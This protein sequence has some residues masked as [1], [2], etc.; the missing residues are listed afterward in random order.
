MQHLLIS[1]AVRPLLPSDYPSQIES[2]YFYLDLEV[3]STGHIIE[4]GLVSPYFQQRYS[5]EDLESLKAILL[6][7]QRQGLTVIGH[8]FRRFDFPY[9]IEWLPELSSLTV[10]DTLE[11]SVILYPLAESHRLQK[12]YKPSQYTGNNPLEDALA[13]RLLLYQ[14]LEKLS[15]IEPTLA[16]SY[17]WLLSCGQDT[18]D[19]AYQEL[20]HRLGYDLTEVPGPNQLAKEI[21]QSFNWQYLDWFWQNAPHFN[22]NLRLSMAAL[23]AWYKEQDKVKTGFPKW[24]THLLEFQSVLDGLSP[25][26][27][28]GF[29]YHFYLE[30]FGLTQFRPPQEEAIQTII[31]G[32]RPLIIMATG[33]GKSL[34]YQLPALMIYQK[35]RRLTVVVS[36]LQALMADQVQDLQ[37]QG[38]NFATYINSSL[39]SPE[40]RQRLEEISQGKKGLLYISPEQLR[41]ISIRSLLEELLPAFWV[42]DE[43]HSI[44]QWGHN[45]RPDYCYVP[46]YI[47]SLYQQKNLPLPR[48]ALLTATATPQV[49]EDLLKL[50]KTYQL[51]IDTEIIGHS[52]RDNLN[53]QVIPSN[54]NRDFILLEQVKASLKQA[55]CIIVYTNTR[56]ETEIIAQQLQKNNLTAAYYHSGL[57]SQDKQDILEDFKKG[58][59][60]IVVATSAFGMGINRADVRSVIHYKMSFSLENYIQESGRAGRDNQSA[61]CVLLFDIKDAETIFFLQS[62]HHLSQRDLENIFVMIRSLRD[63]LYETVKEADFFWVTSRELLQGSKIEESLDAEQIDTKIKVALHH[64][65]EFGLVQREENQSSFIEFHLLHNTPQDSL[66]KF[67]QY[68][69]V[70]QFS[71]SQNVLFEKL[72]YALHSL[73][74]YYKQDKISLEVLSDEAGLNITELKERIEELKMS[75]VCAYQIPLIIQIRKGVKKDAAIERLTYISQLENRLLKILLEID[76]DRLQIN[77]RSLTTILDPD[78]QEQLHSA[79]LWDLLDSWMSR[80]WVKMAKITQ[81]IVELSY[82]TAGD[83]LEN[84]H[85]ITKGI[86]EVI[87]SKLKGQIGA[88]L[89]FQVFLDELLQDTNKAIEPLLCSI[90]EL[91]REL[92]WLH[93]QKILRLIEGLNLFQQSLKIRLIPN[94]RITTITSRYAEINR[95]YQEEARRTHLMLEYGLLEESEKR[96]QL[97]KDYF[98]LSPKTFLRQYPKLA[99][100]ASLRPVTQD[101]Y[102]RIMGTLN[103]TQREIVLS[104]TPSLAV[105]AGPG[106]G[107]TRTIVQKIAYLVK[108]KRISPHR[109]IVL[110]YN[111]NAIRELRIR[112]QSLIGNAAFGLRIFTFHGLALAL[113]GRSLGQ[114]NTTQRE[115]NFPEILRQACQLLE[116]EDNDEESQ[117]RR[118]KLLGNIEY[119]FVDEYQDVAQDEYHLIQLIAGLGK[120]EE[121]SRATEINLCVIG[122]DDQNIYEFRGTNVKYL[123]QFESEYQAKRILLVE[124]YRSSKNII[125]AANNLIKNNVQRC[126]KYTSEQVRINTERQSETGLPVQALLF[127]NQTTQVY[128]IQKNIQQWINNGIK[129]NEIA[130]LSPKWDAL[131]PIRFLLEQI[132]IATY[133]LKKDQIK[134]TRNLVTHRLLKSLSTS[135]NLILSP[136]ESVTSRFKNYFTQLKENLES[137]TVKTLLKIAEDLDLERGQGE[138]TIPITTNEII[139]AIFEYANTG[140]V[141][142][143]DKAVLITS[144]HSAKGLEF[145]QVILLTDHFE[146]FREQERRL[147][148]VA[149]TRAKKELIFCSTKINQFVQ[150]TGISYQVMENTIDSNQILSHRL[151]Y[152]D[153]EP[154]DVNLGYPDT[155]NNQKLIKQL[156]EGDII[157]LVP[158]HRGDNL[159]IIGDNQVIGQ[160]SRAGK[161]RLESKGILLREFKFE[162][163]QVRVKNI[164]CHF[165]I[166]KLTGKI[167]QEWCVIIPQ[168]RL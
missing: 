70:N 64:L 94:A 89:Q 118:I 33:G 73:K 43:A 161:E 9:L 93:E 77:L 30:K 61:S 167:N 11:L 1:Y 100:E 115:I 137:H 22:F 122:D 48:L 117:V 119:I 92:T 27:T 67:Q 20:F 143:E 71:A 4:I 140:E 80:G 16:K 28:E 124:N 41:S 12:N 26:V 108:V 47:Q 128:W 18:A 166:D 3:N 98:N 8:N 34:C 81:D 132:G 54:A 157:D 21:T 86:I 69:Q 139:T 35:Q 38:L 57:N 19:K 5:K 110:A 36:P 107:K 130:I 7:L 6:Q 50:F 104:D 74:N 112:L 56:K 123:I 129:P 2:Q 158:N 44:S 84:H 83:N 105:I 15:T 14:L 40:R 125:Q 144:C 59:L 90:K 111:R 13:T 134:L 109:I 85:Y 58:K 149:M 162:P 10:L 99:T 79:T 75:S 66:K 25:L 136:S 126:K 31:E 49:R 87:Y 39:S 76:A 97:V 42:I 96:Q 127:P 29:S 24:L 101:D 95:Y 121:P 153:L 156:K 165:D 55:G 154:R 146:Q 53:Y 106:S 133:I 17:I 141:Y 155:L 113:L 91:E 151:L 60:N 62:L 65:E 135:N 160:L 23:L 120:S 32:K 148:Y 163:G 51:E 82:L 147:F 45:F 78:G 164:F 168:I 159:L 152:L 88:R 138:D 116:G 72:I 37:Q 142:L 150:E 46:K 63:R 68:S 114:E 145:S 103:A 102:R 131:F 52:V